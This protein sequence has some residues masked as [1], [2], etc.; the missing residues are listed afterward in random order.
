M[1]GLLAGSLPMRAVQAAESAAFVI[2][3]GETDGYGIGDCMR[4]GS[5]CGHVIAD[6]WCEAH[7]HLKSVAFGSADDVTG[8]VGATQSAALCNVL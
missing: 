8:S 7:G 5:A 1:T 2:P 4:S 6:S 3:A